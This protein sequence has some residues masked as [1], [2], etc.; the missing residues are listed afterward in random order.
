MLLD[1]HL[2]A[3]L[4]KLTLYYPSLYKLRL[5]CQKGLH[6]W[7]T[8]FQQGYSGV[9][10]QNCDMF[11]RLVGKPPKVTYDSLFFSKSVLKCVLTW[12]GY[13][14]LKKKRVSILGSMGKASKLQFD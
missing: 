4:Y 8:N 2:G 9:T 14:E 11:I 6:I 5:K 12:F 10:Y 7:L 1:E 13:A 3:Y